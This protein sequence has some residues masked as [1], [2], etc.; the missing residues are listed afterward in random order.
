MN[1]DVRHVSRWNSAA[2][3]TR[4]AEWLATRAVDDV[5]GAFDCATLMV[6]PQHVFP[7]LCL[8]DATIKYHEPFGLRVLHDGMLDTWIGRLPRPY[9]V[10]MAQRCDDQLTYWMT[11][12]L[13]SPR[14]R[15]VSF[16]ADET[17]RTHACGICRKLFAD[18]SRRD[19]HMDCHTRA[20]FGA[21]M[22]ER[23]LAATQA[24]GIFRKLRSRQ[25]PAH[26][27]KPPPRSW[28]PTPV[29]DTDA[30]RANCA[31]CGDELH[32]RWC[33]VANQW[34]WQDSVRVG[35]LIH[36]ECFLPIPSVK[37]LR[38]RLP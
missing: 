21:I 29:H 8:L 7:F 4:W 6:A 32:K 2:D 27:R 5:V 28:S 22:R 18:A 38:C 35:A 36:A 11:L 15:D 37:R 25:V 1:T 13:L 10:R 14:F 23:H 17:P 20:L 33:D 12:G 19:A 31:V 26:A 9:D 16:G 3:I 34:T 30:R 24:L